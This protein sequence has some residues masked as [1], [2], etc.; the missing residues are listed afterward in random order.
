MEWGKGSKDAFSLSQNRP[1]CRR[2]QPVSSPR[3]CQRIWNWVLARSML[4][5][6]LSVINLGGRI[7]RLIWPRRLT[8]VNVGRAS[9]ENRSCLGSFAGSTARSFDLNLLGPTPISMVFS[10]RW[11]STGINRSRDRPQ[12]T[13]W[14]GKD[15]PLIESSRNKDLRADKGQT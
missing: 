2:H 15:G 10:K 5:H 7:Q 4:D 14:V 13:R 3:G 1:L 12:F 8:R 9:R 6:G 11:R